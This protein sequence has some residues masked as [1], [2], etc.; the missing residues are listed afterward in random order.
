MIMRR[1]LRDHGGIAAAE[2]ALMAPLALLLIFMVIN[3]GML[4]EA[5]N[6][7]QHAVGEGARYATIYPRPSDAQITTVIRNAEFGIDPSLATAPT[8]TH[9]T[10]SGIDYIDVTLT[11]SAPVSFPLYNLPAVPM[12]YTKRAYLQ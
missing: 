12:T 10:S 11:Y 8:L 7:L 9:G 2:F 3:V 6:G 4:F 1:V 5:Y